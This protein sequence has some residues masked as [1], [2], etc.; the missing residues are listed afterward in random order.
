[1]EK[2]L[3]HGRGQL[4]IYPLIDLKRYQLTI[5]SFVTL[6][7]KSIVSFLSR[8]DIKANAKIEAPGVYIEH[9]K[10]LH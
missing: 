1:V 9:K 2:L 6:I 3:Y 4:I 8:R 5:R 7:E 10:L